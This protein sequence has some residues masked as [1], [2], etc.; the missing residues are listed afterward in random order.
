MKDKTR[1]PSVD[2]DLNLRDRTDYLYSQNLN[3]ALIAALAFFA[4]VI[5]FAD[6][7]P[8]ELKNILIASMSMVFIGRVI[9][10]M[11][12]KF[13]PAMASTAFYY[14][15]RFKVLAICTGV[16]WAFGACLL[17]EYQTTDEKYFTMVAI[18]S[19]TGGSVIVFATSKLV[20]A[21]YPSLLLLPLSLTAIF[22]G[23]ESMEKVGILAALYWVIMLVMSRRAS[24]M[25]KESIRFKNDQV[26]LRSQIESERNELARAY[27]KLR[28]ANRELDET[29]LTL[30]DK[31]IERTEQIELLSS[32]DSLT[33]LLNRHALLQSLDKQIE[34]ASLQKLAVLFIDLNGFK[35]INDALGHHIGDEVLKRVAT[36][37]SKESGVKLLCRWGGDEFVLVT[38]YENDYLTRNYAERILS[39]IAE[40]I[41]VE[42]NTLKTDASIGVSLYPEH[43]NTPGQLTQQADVAMFKQKRSKGEGVLFYND[44]LQL[45]VV[46]QQ[47]LLSGLKQSIKQHQL[48]LVYQPIINAS[49]DSIW[50]FETLVRWQFKSQLIRPDE[51]I[52]LAEK[53]GFIVEMGM[54]VLHRACSEFTLLPN[55]HNKHLSVNVSAT[56]LNDKN[57]IVRLTQILESTTFDPQRLHLEITESE[58]MGGDEQVIDTL[59]QVRKMGISMSI[60]DFGTGYSN[61]SQLTRLPATTI[62]IDKSCISGALGGNDVI[63]RASLLIAN[64]FQYVTVAEG[65]ETL[66][67][68]DFLKD[69]GID[70]L[71][72]FYFAKPMQ[73][74]EAGEWLEEFEARR[75]NAG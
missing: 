55:H 51:F 46:E 45:E 28:D 7:A 5:Y 23:D 56:Q 72:G 52:P 25:S 44:E 49:D 60:D 47:R 29:N 73:L 61:L 8:A 39:V 18:G 58:L 30:E 48:F 4:L 65:V 16:V 69:R 35:S 26:L 50:G 67:Q 20:S 40:P 31:V 24:I 9:D 74:N 37:L 57:F 2:R 32:V 6:A 1:L 14:N 66:E 36:R 22:T 64:E 42:E 33:N 38:A 21:V 41:D 19:M 59:N 53:T 43:A 62:K 3:G 17:F 63:V 54:W 27:A 12:W 34:D 68:A 10:W 15:L 75:V 13:R 70:L 71:Q 11:Y